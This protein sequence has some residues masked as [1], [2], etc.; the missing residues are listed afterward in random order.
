MAMLKT[1]SG[2]LVT[3]GKELANAAALA[4]YTVPQAGAMA[5]LGRNASYEAVQRGEIPVLRFGRLLRVPKA[6]WDAI[7][8]GTTTAAA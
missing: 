1:K 3:G 7:L 2:K 4:V 5:G 8:A 6:A